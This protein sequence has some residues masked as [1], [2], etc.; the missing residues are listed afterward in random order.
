MARILIRH[1]VSENL[2]VKSQVCDVPEWGTYE[3]ACD[4][5]D[6]ADTLAPKIN[7]VVVE[8][9]LGEDWRRRIR[10]VAIVDSSSR[11]DVKHKIFYNPSSGR[12]LCECEGFRY[13]RQPIPTCKHIKNYLETRRTR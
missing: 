8:V 5:G 6:Y 3:E 9:D 11:A 10:L 2:W 1:G 4:L 13:S 7:G 12:Y